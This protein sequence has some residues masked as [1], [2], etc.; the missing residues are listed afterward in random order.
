MPR[1]VYALAGFV[2][3]SKSGSLSTA[4]TIQRAAI[5][6]MAIVGLLVL[7]ALLNALV[8]IY[9]TFEMA[10]QR[11]I[12]GFVQAAKIVLYAIVGIIIVSIIMGK[13][14]NLLLG[15]LGALI[16]GFAGK[17]PAHWF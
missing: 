6:Y 12:R 10:R 8:D 4:T 1:L 13:S 16:F 9:R 7:D 3:Y 17:A 2:G 5:V 11:P 15:G 14:P